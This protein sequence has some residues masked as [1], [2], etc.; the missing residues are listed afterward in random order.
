MKLVS[1]NVSLPKTV[2]WGSRSVQTGI[3]K[4][5]VSGAVFVGRLNLDGDGQADPKYHG[6][7][8]KAVYTYPAGHYAYWK[9]ALGRSD[10][11]YGTFGENFTVEGM[12]ETSVR[13]GDVYELA[14]GARVQVT[15][16]RTPCPKLG[17]K[18]GSLRFVKR[19]QEAGRPGFYMRVLKE[20]LVEAGDAI[21]LVESDPSLPTVSQ[22][23][24]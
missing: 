11:P 1:V 5:P 19:F 10:L 14:G 21:T 23:F 16:P 12:L 9:E 15:R 17:M 7:P 6:G 24:K 2:R 18:M 4:E 20:G 8:D 22:I 3:Y 13:T